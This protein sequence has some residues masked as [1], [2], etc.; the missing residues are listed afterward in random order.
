MHSVKLNIKDNV[1]DDVMFFIN[2][3]RQNVDVVE[4]V[5][6]EK[7]ILRTPRIISKDTKK[8]IKERKEREYILKYYGSLDEIY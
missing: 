7:K 8:L 2:N 5:D 6:N 3:F 4:D 1:Y